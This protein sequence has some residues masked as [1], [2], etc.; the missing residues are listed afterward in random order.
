ML[1]ALSDPVKLTLGVCVAA[2]LIALVL[3][4]FHKRK[5]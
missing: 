1:F 4:G 3:Y 2:V 5:I